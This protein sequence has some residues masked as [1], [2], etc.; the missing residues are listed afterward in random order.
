MKF[1]D[2]HCHVEQL[3]SLERSL[4]DAAAG[5]VHRIVAVAEDEAS[6]LKIRDLQTQRFPTEVLL[7]VGYHPMLTPGRESADIDSALKCVETFASEA[8]VIGEIGLDHKYAVSEDD[9]SY[10]REI[11]QRQL[12][13]AAKARKPINLHSRWALRETM[14]VAVDFTKETGLGAQ[15]HWF[16]QSKKLIRKTN[17]SGVYV[18]VGPSILHSE[19]ARTVA[20]TIDRKL[21]LLETDGPVEF[22]G[23]P[24]EPSWIPKIAAAVAE[25]WECDASE[26]SRQTEENFERYL[27]KAHLR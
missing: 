6:I 26:V 22:A 17:E 24:A 13:I 1:T 27:G 20:S 12:E 10:Q 9:K 25:L 4:L 16:T 2:T 7:G 5:G 18:S 19:Q 23:E 21:L 3:P 11:L 8:T 15:L 14:N